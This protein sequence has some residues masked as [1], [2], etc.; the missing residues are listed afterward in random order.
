MT[1]MTCASRADR[2]RELSAD[3]VARGVVVEDGIGT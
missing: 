3:G 2:I 1:R